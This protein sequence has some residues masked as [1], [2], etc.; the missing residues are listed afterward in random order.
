M[1]VDESR[2]ARVANGWQ[3]TDWKSAEYMYLSE[4]SPEKL[5]GS[6]HP[7][8]RLGVLAVT[9]MCAWCSKYNCVRLLQSSEGVGRLSVFFLSPPFFLNIQQL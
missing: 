2:L 8:W 3:V 1:W 5:L 7:L 4:V 6:R 9:R